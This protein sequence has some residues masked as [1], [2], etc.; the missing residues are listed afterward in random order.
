[1]NALVETAAGQTSTVEDAIRTESSEWWST[2]NEQKDVDEFLDGIEKYKDQFYRFVKRTVWD[3]GVVEDVFS[4]A[5]LAA[6]ENRHK[7]TPGTNFRAWMFRILQNKCFIANRET[8]RAMAPLEKAEN[9]DVI[10]ADAPKHWDVLNDPMKVLDECGDEVYR[11]IKSLSPRQRACI[12]LRGVERLS[13]REIATILEIPEATVMTHLSR[14]R[15]KL[16]EQL[17]EYATN[18]GILSPAADNRRLVQT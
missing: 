3:Q 2:K 13:Y 4:S 14:G 9:A 16:R 18:L 12:M 8:G 1:M 17:T 11:A 7:Y 10:A 15:A 5:V 6:Y